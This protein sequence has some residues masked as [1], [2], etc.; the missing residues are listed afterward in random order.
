MNHYN[1]PGFS[2]IGP[3]R[4]QA[5]REVRRVL[6]RYIGHYGSY[7]TIAR[8]LLTLDDTD[9]VLIGEDLVGWVY[10]IGPADL[11]PDFD[12]ALPWRWMSTDPF[13]DGQGCC[14]SRKEAVAMLFKCWVEFAVK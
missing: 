6:D 10:E 12:P 4:V 8:D 9:P 13:G 7:P 1:D 2:V 11:D 5:L 14:A 3:A